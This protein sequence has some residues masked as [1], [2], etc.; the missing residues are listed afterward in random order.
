MN[1]TVYSDYYFYILERLGITETEIRSYSNLFRTMFEIDF[2][3]DVT[4]DRDENRAIDGKILREDY[5]ND[6]NR[7]IDDIIP[8]SFLEMIAGLAIRCENDIMWV[9]DVDNTRQ[10]FWD[11]LNNTRLEEYDNNNWNRKA[12]IDIINMVIYRQ[13]DYSGNGGLFPLR[14]PETDQRRVEIW[15]QLASWLNENYDLTG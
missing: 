4:I 7:Y 3:W 11:M 8:C 14:D 1:A 5:E 9:P 2:K 10:W 15:Y 12:V 13:Y 6:T